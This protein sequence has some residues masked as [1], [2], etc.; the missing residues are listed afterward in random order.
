M[1][2]LSA[3]I[4]VTVTWLVN[5]N[6]FERSVVRIQL[7]L[8]SRWQNLSLARA[9]SELFSI[10]FSPDSLRSPGAVLGASLS[11]SGHKYP[12]ELDPGAARPAVTCTS[13][14]SA[15]ASGADTPNVSS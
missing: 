7:G 13:L 8:R 4:L 14:P 10:S 11:L 5:G 15:Q 1:I 2:E 6:I 12:R 9:G 3:R